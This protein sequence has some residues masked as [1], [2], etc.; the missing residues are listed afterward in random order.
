MK[1][2]QVKLGLLMMLPVLILSNNLA[3]AQVSNTTT[4]TRQTISPQNNR[5]NINIDV[6]YSDDSDKQIICRDDNDRNCRPHRPHRPHKNNDHYMF[7]YQ[8]ADGCNG[9]YANPLRCEASRN[10]IEKERK[11]RDQD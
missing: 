4:I 10:Q 11:E 1:Y 9:L 5:L 2:F 6:D 3:Q 7:R 8:N